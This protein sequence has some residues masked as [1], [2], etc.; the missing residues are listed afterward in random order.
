MFRICFTIS[1]LLTAFTSFASHIVGGEMI[2]E[3]LN[4][5]SAANT[6]KYRVTL[7]L[8]R[9]EHCTMCAPMPEDVYIGI[10]NNDDG[11]KVGDGSVPYWDVNKSSE[12]SVPVGSLPPCITNAPNLDYHVATYSFVVDLANNKTGYTAAFQTCCRVNPLANVFNIPN[13]GATGATYTATIPGVDQLSTGTN[14]SPKFNMGVS[15]ICSN[16]PFTLD[17]SAKDVDGDDLVYSFCDAYGGGPSENAA[18][19]SPAAPPYRA[20]PYING[21]TGDQPLGSKATIN[22]KTGIISGTAPDVGE[23]VVCV[24]IS[25][26]RAGKL[27]GTH[28]K[29]FIVNVNNCDFAGAQLQPSYINCNDFNYTFQNLNPSPLNKTYLW[30]FGDNTTSTDPTPSHTYA[31]AGVYEVKLVINKAQDCSDSTTSNIKVYPGFSP[32]FTTSG[33][34]INKTTQFKDTTKSVYG[35]VNY[36]SWV[37][38]DPTSTTNTSALQ[39]PTHSYSAS[40]TKNIQFIVGD[41]KGCLDTINR[42]VIIVDKPTINVGFK[43]TLICIG[44]QVQLQANGTGTFTWT[45]QTAITGGN[46]ATPTVHPTVTTSYIVQLNDDGC[47]NNDTVKVNVVS[48]V[49]L[50]AMADTT[51][52]AGDPVLLGAVT[53][54]FKYVWTPNETLDNSTSLNPVAKPSTTTT[55]QIRSFIGGCSSTDN[56]TIRTVP[57]P[58]ANAGLDTVTCYGNTA[59]LHGSI[60]GSSFS[61]GSAAGLTNANT[62]SP[63]ATAASTASYV[64]FAMDTLGCPKPGI[65]SVLVTV[66]PKIQA[67]AGRD[68]TVVAG[69]SLQFSATGGTSYL[70]NPATSLSNPAIPNPVGVYDGSFD[71]ITY[72]VYI[73]NDYGCTDSASVRVKIFKTEPQVFVPTAFTPNGDGKNDVF[74]PIA[75]GISRIDYFKVYNRWGQLVFS[76]TINELGWDGKI[77]GADQPSG[78][79]VWLVKGVDFAGKQFSA[80]GTVTLIR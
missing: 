48:T 41:S 3:Y 51:I 59:Q 53:N 21:F 71:N 5:G 44:D 40:G 36:W 57:Y 62:L 35:T 54:G 73:A 31:N 14:S 74:R 47:I 52:C 30:N 23:Y 67:F 10:F 78:V 27:I 70:W 69:Q 79:Y 75:A 24:C 29:D 64:L 6:Q 7:L 49:A 26:F 77:N 60:I 66:L 20:V 56:V 50:K 17:F 4:P 25:E 9:D 32:G 39:N 33:I 63:T 38:G 19:I 28:R 76:T 37:L 22:S 58:V 43:D 42:D 2:Y 72:R 65:D 18:N 80:K 8:Y 1:L 16:K 15:I 45:P 34:C 55:Y 68:T 61:W 12:N 11:S 46:T 13:A